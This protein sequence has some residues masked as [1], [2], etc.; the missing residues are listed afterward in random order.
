MK[1]SGEL[2]MLREKMIE[3]LLKNADSK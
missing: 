3:K 2:E 1:E